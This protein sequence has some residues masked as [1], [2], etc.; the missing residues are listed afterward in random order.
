[1]GKADRNAPDAPVPDFAYTDRHDGRVF[2]RLLDGDGKYRKKTIGYLT[3]SATGEERMIP[4]RYFREK[5][6]ELYAESCPEVIDYSA[7]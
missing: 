1:M 4:N 3:D 5:Y 6:R 2:V 7:P